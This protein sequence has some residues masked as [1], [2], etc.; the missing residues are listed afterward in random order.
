MHLAEY[1]R[2]RTSKTTVR[3]IT[4]AIVY[5]RLRFPRRRVLV[6]STKHN[7]L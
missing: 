3:F 5:S 4:K 7:T 1:F 2:R 6:N